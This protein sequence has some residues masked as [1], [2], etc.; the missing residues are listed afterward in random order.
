M[1]K[2]WGNRCGI[3]LAGYAAIVIN[4]SCCCLGVAGVQSSHNVQ[5][6]HIYMT[7]SQHGSHI[8]LVPGAAV[9]ATFWVQ[10]DQR[11]GIL[12]IP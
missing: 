8:G 4:Y 7:I 1:P 3:Y 2:G 12:Y 9:G 5:H 6:L 10:E 11:L